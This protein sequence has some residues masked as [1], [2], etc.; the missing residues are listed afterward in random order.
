MRSLFTRA[1]A[2]LIAQ[3]TTK[4]PRVTDTSVASRIC[5]KLASRRSEMRDANDR[6]ARPSARKF[7]FDGV[8]EL[9]LCLAHGEHTQTH[10]HTRA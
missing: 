5:M 10:T 3:A 4:W 6:G 9:F 2:R 7:Q 1:R 8:L